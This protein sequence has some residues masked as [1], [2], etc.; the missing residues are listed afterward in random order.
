MQ[1]QVGAPTTTEEQQLR[2]ILQRADMFQKLEELDLM[3]Q[4]L[5]GQLLKFTNAIQGWQ[6]R[7]CVLDPA[8]GELRYYLKC[9]VKSLKPRGVLNLANAEII[10]SEDDSMTFSVIPYGCDVYRFKA[11]DTKSKQEWINRLRTIANDHAE[12]R[13]KNLDLDLIVK[14]PQVSENVYRGTALQAT[15]FGNVHKILTAASEQHA[16]LLRCFDDLPAA[17]LNSPESYQ[18]VLSIKSYS[19]SLLTGLKDC[20]MSLRLLQNDLSTFQTRSSELEASLASNA[21]QSIEYAPAK[22]AVSSVEERNKPLETSSRRVDMTEFKES[23]EMPEQPDFFEP[24][25]G[26]VESQKKAILSLLSKLKLGTDLTRVPLPAFLSQKRSFLESCSDFLANTSTFVSIARCTSS[27]K[28]LVAILKWYLT[29]FFFGCKGGVA[30]KPFNPVAGELFTCSWVPSGD[31]VDPPTDSQ[32]LSTSKVRFHAEQ[33]SHHPPVTA[34][35]ASTSNRDVLLTGSISVRSKF[36]GVS[37]NMPILCEAKVAV[38]CPEVEPAVSHDKKSNYEVYRLHYPNCFARSILTTPSMEFGGKVQIVSQQTG[39]AAVITFHT[40]PFYGGKSHRVTA[41][42]RTPTG[43]VFCRAEGD[44]RELIEFTYS[45]GSVETIDVTQIACQAMTSAVPKN[46]VKLKDLDCYATPLVDE[47]DGLVQDRIPIVEPYILDCF[48]RFRG[49]IEKAED[50]VQQANDLNYRMV[51]KAGTFFNGIVSRFVDLAEG[52]RDVTPKATAIFLGTLGGLAMGIQ[53][54]GILS[55]F[56]H[57]GGA[58]TLMTTF[59]YPEETCQLFRSWKAAGCRHYYHWCTHLRAD[60]VVKPICSQRYGHVHYSKQTY[61]VITNLEVAMSKQALLDKFFDVG[62]FQFG[63]FTLKCGSVSPVYID[64]RRLISYPELLDCVQ[65]ELWTLTQNNGLSFKRICGVPYGAIPVCTALSVG[66]KLPMLFLRKEAKPYGTKQ[67]VEGLYDIGDRCLIVEDVITH[68]TSV[69]NT[70]EV[71]RSLGLIVTDALIILDRCQGGKN[72]LSQSGITARSLFNLKEVV[73]HFY[74][75]GKISG[76]NYNRVIA[77]L[78]SPN[79][80]ACSH[81]VSDESIS[82]IIVAVEN[83]PSNGLYCNRNAALVH[84]MARRLWDIIESKKT[85]LCIACDFQTKDE[86]L[87]TL[88]LVGSLIC[89]AK[90]HAD[91]V[92]DFD[93]K[94]AADL[95]KLAKEK[96]FLILEDRKFADTGDV[97]KKQ[98][99]HS[100]YKPTIWADMVTLHPI[101]GYGILQAIRDVSATRSLACL[102]VAEMSTDG[103]LTSNNYRADAVTMAKDFRDVVAGFISQKRPAEDPA[104]LYFTPGVHFRA[105]TDRIGQRWRSIEAAVKEDGNDVAIVGRAITN[106]SNILEA[107]EKFRHLA[108]EAFLARKS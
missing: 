48:A 50:V 42:A 70:T 49:T 105:G 15:A 19:N 73:H 97:V 25:L 22:R 26:S 28:R 65:E 35:F 51:Y 60:A 90:L 37:I 41:E 69:N 9:D 85:N 89:M 39:N 3:R 17:L 64:L 54:G 67:L 58:A 78:S 86:I 13:K 30:R 87:Q 82:P 12:R 44:W 38:L 11:Q 99:L 21:G 76:E 47:Y 34:F 100:I 5:E 29:S 31:F 10:P 63:Q 53:R 101:A 68:G 33:M 8:K 74:S 88:Q 66:H 72:S 2:E 45:D 61:S 108:W 75:T 98:L 91:I 46:V 14:T 18:A 107:T 57:A 83:A 103:N 27:E 43:R 23:D 81:C 59:C 77:Y 20:A 4:P 24:E 104:F 1:S 80:E 62:V 79:E 71:L 40:K 106:D 7:W 102:I 93:L 32:P 94:F 16:S 52:T 92:E 84:P 96:N 95:R 6:N 36:M 55:V 56:K